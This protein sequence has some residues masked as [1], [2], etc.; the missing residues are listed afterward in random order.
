MTTC[1]LYAVVAY[2]AMFNDCFECERFFF[3][4][5]PC[6]RM[7]LKS[8]K[9]ELSQVLYSSPHTKDVFLFFKGYHPTIPR[10]LI[11]HCAILDPEVEERSRD[12]KDHCKITYTIEESSLLG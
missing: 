7:I 6:K 1:Q 3:V 12:M 9:A 2:W 8:E 11:M 4:P 10:T 5:N